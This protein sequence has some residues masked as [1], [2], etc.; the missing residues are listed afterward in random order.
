M[1]FKKFLVALLSAALIFTLTACGSEEKSDVEKYSVKIG[2]LKYM[3]VGEQQFNDFM[4]KIAETFSLKI[5][6]HEVVFFDNLNSMQMAYNAGQIDE[7]STYTS[8]AYYLAA[9]NPNVAVLKDHTLE[10]VDAFCLA[11]RESDEDLFQQVDGA[12]KKMRDDGTLE[13][14]EKKY[15]K[16]LKAGEEPEAVEIEKFEGADTIKVAITGDLPPIDLILAD[17]KPAGFN[18]AVLS[19]IGK[20]LQKNIELVQIESAARAAALESGRVDI[21]FWAIVPMSEIIPANAD[22]PDGVVLS[23]PYYRGT[24]I[25][26]GFDGEKI[27]TTAGLGDVVGNLAQ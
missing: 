25:H 21:S 16:D 20:R 14:L 15:I 23:T 10:F 18:T 12:V 9:R 2:M 6:P 5:T 7:I 17:G 27:D 1:K 13:N 19:E 8:V 4:K 3:N 24:I 26:V 22:K 11:M